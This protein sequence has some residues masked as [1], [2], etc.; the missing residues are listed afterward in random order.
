M[1]LGSM[2]LYSDLDLLTIAAAHV[3]QCGSHKISLYT[4]FNVF[5][6]YFKHFL[7]S[8]DVLR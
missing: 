5:F 7:K 3:V 2:F 1:V 6:S 8:F 4:S